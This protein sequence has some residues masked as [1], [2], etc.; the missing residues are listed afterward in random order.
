MPTHSIKDFCLAATLA[1]VSLQ[2]TLASPSQRVAGVEVEQ[3]VEGDERCR[4]R[5]AETLHHARAQ[6]LFLEGK[7]QKIVSYLKVLLISANLL[8]C[9]EHSE[10]SLLRLIIPWRAIAVLLQTTQT[11][12]RDLYYFSLLNQSQPRWST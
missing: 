10:A 11:Q 9:L 7:E 1:A 2:K 5:L 3:L 6:V 4:E 12:V 8:A